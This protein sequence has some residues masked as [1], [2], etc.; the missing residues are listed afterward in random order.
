[1]R[2]EASSQIYVASICPPLLKIQL[3]WSRH[4]CQPNWRAEEWGGH[5]RGCYRYYLFL[6]NF[7][8]MVLPSA[9][10]VSLIKFWTH[11]FPS[12]SAIYCVFLSFTHTQ[13]QRFCSQSIDP[14]IVTLDFNHQVCHH[15]CRVHESSSFFVR[16]VRVWI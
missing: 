8:T 1:M 9:R 11:S 14:S 6:L 3:N 7:V 2:S 4:V 15:H 10:M 16:K 5:G 12:P 13:R